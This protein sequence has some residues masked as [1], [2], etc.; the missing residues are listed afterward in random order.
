MQL[1]QAADAEYLV[2]EVTGSEGPATSVYV[3]NA[4]NVVVGVER[5]FAK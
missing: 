4:R 3:K 5:H 2:A 1:P